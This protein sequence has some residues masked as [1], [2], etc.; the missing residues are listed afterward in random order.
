VIDAR[1]SPAGIRLVE[2]EE[3]RSLKAV[4]VGPAAEPAWPPAIAKHEEHV[5]IRVGELREL[6]A[7]AGV[8]PEW[9]AGFDAMLE[10]ARSRG[11][12]DE[13]ERAVRAH[14]ERRPE[15]PEAG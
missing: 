4:V 13:T 11:W 8:G 1:E 2:P 15:P 10:F 3:L 5:W 9:Q 14:V 6:A 12:V 7:A